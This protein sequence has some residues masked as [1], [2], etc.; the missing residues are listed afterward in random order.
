M[1]RRNNSILTLFTTSLLLW[2][3]RREAMTLLELVL[4]KAA[5]YTATTTI[6]V[7]VNDNANDDPPKPNN[8]DTEKQRRQD[9]RVMCGADVVITNV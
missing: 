5:I 6:V 4:W 7:G 2:L 3:E 8:D 1:T 9:C